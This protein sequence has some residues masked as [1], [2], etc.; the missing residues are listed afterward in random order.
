MV[1]KPPQIAFFYDEAGK[2]TDRFLA[3][4]ALVVTQDDVATVRREFIR[5][6]ALLSINA[7]AKWNLTRKASHRLQCIRRYD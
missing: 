3:V 6:K 7:D 4:G 5:R 1:E 2:D